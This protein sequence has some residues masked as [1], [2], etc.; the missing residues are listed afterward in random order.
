MAADR[1]RGAALLTVLL[2]VA[3]IAVLAGTALERLRLTTRLAGNALAGEQA[4]GYAR[5]AEALATTKVTDMLGT[6][7]DR[8]TLAGGWSNRP[9]GLPL[10]GGGLAV[11][12]VR[13]GGN[14]FN[15]NGLVTRLGP[16]VYTSTQAITQRI[17]FVRLMRSLNVPAQSAERIAAAA[18]DWID[19][20][21]DQQG[22]GAEDPVYLARAT[23]Y[24]TAGTL[25]ADPSELRAVDGVTPEIYAQLRPWICTLPKAEPAPININTL[26]P[27][28]APLIA[29]MF[30]GNLSADAIRGMLLRRPP[31]GFKD[32]STFLNL[33]G[34]GASPD[35]GNGG[36]A[37]TS[38][39]FA[40]AIDVSNGG[41]QLQERALIDASRLPARLVARQWGD[42]S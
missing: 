20:D 25:M 37:V 9:F 34:N 38:T 29:M 35:G 30:P 31:Q 6:S 40:L 10:P 17:Q 16:G 7:R 1:E 36:L 22:N 3:M 13:D 2:L 12:R 19:T 8:V 14:C 11:A 32:A 18:A 24:R 41:T 33:A 27:E 23:P 26:L 21:Q 15:L 42:E 5:A 28:Q 4:R 39:W